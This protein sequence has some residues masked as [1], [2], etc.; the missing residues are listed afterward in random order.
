MTERHLD[1]PSPLSSSCWL[2]ETDLAKHTTFAL[3]AGLSCHLRCDNR[4]NTQSPAC[5]L[6]MPVNAVHML[7][8]FQ[9]VFPSLPPAA[10]WQSSEQKMKKRC[11]SRPR[12]QLGNGVVQ[13]TESK[14]EKMNYLLITFTRSPS[15]ILYSSSH[16]GNWENKTNFNKDCMWSR[17]QRTQTDCNL[18][19]HVWCW[20][21]CPQ[22]DFFFCLQCAYSL[23]LHWDESGCVYFNVSLPPVGHKEKCTV[24]TWSNHQSSEQQFGCWLG[25]LGHT[26]ITMWKKTIY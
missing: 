23:Y 22:M 21:K 18:K 13:C 6:M 20:Q 7:A 1:S 24:P 8:L 15:S 11:D 4:D 9:T 2:M 5:W 3:P 19:Q 16:Q 12:Y 25:Q 17:F 26:T 14:K 10:L